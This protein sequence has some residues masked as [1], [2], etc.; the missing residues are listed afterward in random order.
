[1]TGPGAWVTPIEEAGGEG[2]FADAAAAR[3]AYLHA[4]TAESRD[5]AARAQCRLAQMLYFDGRTDTAQE[6]LGE[7]AES[8][9]AAWAGRAAALLGDIRFESGDLDGAY[10]AYQRAVV[11]GAPDRADQALVMLA[12]LIDQGRGGP[13]AREEFAALDRPGVPEERRAYIRATLLRWQGELKAA[14][15]GFQQL[16]QDWIAY[17]AAAARFL[18][19]R[20]R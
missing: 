1:M 16:H 19:G 3:Q 6:V 10:P 15:S 5:D 9:P 7:L 8:G 17:Y 11:L 14:E 2:Q 4:A 18:A 13:A 12:L 20:D